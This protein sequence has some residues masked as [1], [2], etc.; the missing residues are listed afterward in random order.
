MP[1]QVAVMNSARQRVRY[2]KN[3]MYMYT[4]IM[5]A[6]KFLSIYLFFYYPLD[7]NRSRG[8]W[9]GDVS[10]VNAREGRRVQIMLH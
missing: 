5:L 4:W 8:S 3:A 6:G 2:L 7:V 9:R 10:R 1:E